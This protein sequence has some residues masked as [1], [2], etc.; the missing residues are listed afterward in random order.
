MK[1]VRKQTDQSSV[2]VPQV[3]IFEVNSYQ[4]EDLESRPK[5]D[6]VVEDTTQKLTIEDIAKKTLRGVMNFD[7]KFG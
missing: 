1:P 2:S 4:V 3:N 5:P 6:L 7:D